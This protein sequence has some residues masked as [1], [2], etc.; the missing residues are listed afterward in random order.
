[1]HPGDLVQLCNSGLGDDQDDNLIS[2]GEDNG[3]ARRTFP[4]CTLCVYL[5]PNL[6]WNRHRPAVDILIDGITGWVWQNEIVPAT[7]ATPS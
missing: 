7:R 6:R 1:M 3:P 5:G 2:I 4:V